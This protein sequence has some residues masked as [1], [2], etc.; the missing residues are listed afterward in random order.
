MTDATRAALMAAFNVAVRVGS[1][2]VGADHL[3]AAL[4]DPSEPTPASQVLRGLG[5][6]EDRVQRL[7]ELERTDESQPV[8]PTPAVYTVLGTARG[9][10]L[11]QGRP[12]DE[13]HV[14]LALAYGDSGLV[15]ATFHEF[16]IT[17]ESIVAGLAERGVAVPPQPP[18]AAPSAGPM[19]GITFAASDLK[20][21]IKVLLREYPPGSAVRW[22]WNQADDRG[23][24]YT[25]SAEAIE[26][27]RAT[28]DDPTTVAPVT[29]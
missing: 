9:L 10:A 2:H 8:T 17:R 25:D 27:V 16:G 19:E 21:V 12:V 6:T 24:I 5:V 13:S 3:L 29:A 7:F 26:L 22:G 18:P 4:A 28:V 1:G 14:L 11:A 20:A 15:D 23:V